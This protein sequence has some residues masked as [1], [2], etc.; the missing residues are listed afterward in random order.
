LFVKQEHFLPNAC[1]VQ[2]FPRRVRQESANTTTETIMA[3]TYAKITARGFGLY[4][5]FVSSCVDITTYFT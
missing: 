5:R 2:P 1:V 3:G 4:Q